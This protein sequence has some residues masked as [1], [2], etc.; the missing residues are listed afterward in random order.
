MAKCIGH[1]EFPGGLPSVGSFRTC[2]FRAMHEAA[3][4]LRGGR[5]ILFDTTL[6]N[7]VGVYDFADPQRRSDSGRRVGQFPNQCS[8][9]FSSGA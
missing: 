4:C 1:A 8:P 7:R 3:K 2:S 6:G 9:R 5:M